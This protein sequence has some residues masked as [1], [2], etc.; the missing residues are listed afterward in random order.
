MKYPII[1]VFTLLFLV[2]LTGCCILDS[3][4]R[5]SRSA[6][7]EEIDKQIDILCMNEQ[8]SQESTY[9][10]CRQAWQ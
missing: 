1:I 8:I 10:H 9:K 7:D 4:N 5:P 2:I 3:V 6:E